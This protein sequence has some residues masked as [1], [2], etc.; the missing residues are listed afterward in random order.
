MKTELQAKLFQNTLSKNKDHD[1]FTIIELLIV[2]IL[3]GI[4]SAIALPS[5]L[6]KAKRAQESEAK[7]YIGAVNRAQQVY[8]MENTAFAPDIDTLQIGI[9]VSTSNYTYRLDPEPTY[10]NTVTI[11]ATAI[12]LA[13][14]KGFNGGVTVILTGQTLAVACQTAGPQA[15]NPITPPSLTLMGADCAGTMKKMD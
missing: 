1:G 14:L 15:T 8:R 10:T 7:T 5:F 9:P 2:F 13:N 4:L 11:T 6:S 12:D 3:V